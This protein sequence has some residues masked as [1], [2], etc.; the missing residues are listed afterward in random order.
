MSTLRNI[1]RD[2]WRREYGS[3]PEMDPLTEEDALLEA[4]V[5]D[6]E[7]DALR[8][9]VAILF[10]LRLALQL[11]DGNTGL[12]VLDGVTAFDWHAEPRATAR[13][14]WN[15]VGSVPRV[16]GGMLEMTIGML[17]RA[18]LFLRAKSAAFY[19]GDVPGLR[20]I[21]D[22]GDASDTELHAKLAHWDSPFTPVHAVFLRNVS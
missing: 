5:L 12:L 21:P 9:R 15:V 10:E 6:I 2:A 4:Q 22:Y 18:D 17:P 14:A 8:S 1:A 16:A 7:I 20:E 11:R 19:S 3:K 13:T